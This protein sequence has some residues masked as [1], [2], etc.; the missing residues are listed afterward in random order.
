MQVHRLTELEQ[1]MGELLF[2]ALEVLP[3]LRARHFPFS[4]CLIDDVVVV[5]I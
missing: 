4:L 5:R 1:R 2:D 3:V